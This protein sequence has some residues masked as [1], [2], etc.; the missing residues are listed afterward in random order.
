MIKPGER[1]YAM[2]SANET[3]VFLFGFGVYNGLHIPPPEVKFMGLTL[4]EHDY[5]NPQITLG[6]GKK[7]F[8]CECWWG[9]E[10]DFESVRKDREVVMVDI[11]QKRKELNGDTNSDEISPETSGN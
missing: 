4:H 5:P 3:H 2:M 7:V 9:A 8:G 6:D 11:E 10:A 1:A